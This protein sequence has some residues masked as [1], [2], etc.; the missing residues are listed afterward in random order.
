MGKHL[1]ELEGCRVL[2]FDLRVSD[3]AS[4]RMSRSLAMGISGVQ[5][6]GRERLGLGASGIEGTMTGPE[7]APTLNRRVRWPKWPAIPSRNGAYQD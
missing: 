4:I 6:F 2:L 7:T 1:G 5:G 3:G